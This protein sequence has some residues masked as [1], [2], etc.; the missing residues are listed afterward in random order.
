M[1]AVV[2][3]YDTRDP[4]KMEN[5]DKDSQPHK[6]ERKAKDKKIFQ[7]LSFNLSV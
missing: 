3:E 4:G 6:C 1:M 5:T 2:C 7:V